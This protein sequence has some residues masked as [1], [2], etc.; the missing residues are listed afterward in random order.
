MTYSYRSI[1]RLVWPLALGMINNAV[2]QFVD[3]AYLAHHSMLSLEACLPS[4]ALAGVFVGFFQSVVGF[5]SVLVAQYYGAADD[6][7][8]RKSYHAGL[9]LA[10]ASGLL[11][12]PLMPLGWWI[13]S[14][15]SPS[16][17]LFASER[18]YYDVVMAGAIFLFGQMAASSYFT[19]RGRT[20]LVF[21]LPLTFV[22]KYFGGSI[23]WLWSTML[24]YVIVISIGSIIRWRLGAWKNIKVLEKV[25]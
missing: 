7:S 4:S 5:T 22:V 20:R 8:C 3:R 1:I 13:F 6:S 21:C 9:L 18:A 16:A 19:G 14:L 25:L 17:E 11:M 12:L 10:L 2:M 15:A 23:L 24:V